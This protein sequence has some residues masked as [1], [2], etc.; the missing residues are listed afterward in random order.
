MSVLR[1]SGRMEAFLASEAERR[2][3]DSA[4]KAREAFLAELAEIYE[5]GSAVSAAL[6]EVGHLSLTA[7]VNE[8]LQLREAAK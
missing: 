6:A 1:D 5:L 8:T 4:R 3:R 7:W 2:A